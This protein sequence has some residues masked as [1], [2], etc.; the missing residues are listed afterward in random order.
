MN[1]TKKILC[2][3]ALAFN[4]LA[5]EPLYQADFE[6]ATVGSMPDD[7]LVLDGGFAV[8]QDGDNKYLEL[9]GS[10]LDTFGL[11]FGPSLKENATATAR[12]F[13]EA[14]GRRYPSFDL[15][16]N[17][18]GGYRLRVSP[19]KKQLE[20][21]R[22]DVLR[23]SVPLDWKP[24]QWTHLKLT[25]LKNG[26]SQ[27]T[28]LGKIWPEGAAEPAQP[29]IE[30]VDSEAPPA[31]RASVFGMPYSGAPIRFDDFSVS[32]AKPTAK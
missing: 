9:P 27:W 30:Y 32:T 2:V 1:R 3:F 24:G 29:S 21:F 26:D 4:S 15:G 23:K 12:F 5:A 13:G 25:V 18:V 11:L 7:F 28:V 17:G 10:P 19:G 22:G 16:L 20:L 8:K 6:K 14:K 31:G